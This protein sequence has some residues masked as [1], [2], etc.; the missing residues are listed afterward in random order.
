MNQ[1]KFITFVAELAGIS[2]AYQ[3]L[4]CKERKPYVTKEFSEVV[5]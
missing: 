3:S 5:M 4:S 2:Q 1:P